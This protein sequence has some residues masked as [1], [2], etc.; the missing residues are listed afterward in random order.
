MTARRGRYP[1]MRERIL[2]LSFVDPVTECWL[3]LGK[4]TRGKTGNAPPRPRMNVWQDGKARTVGAHREAY[5]AFNGPILAGFEVGH[6][7]ENTLCVNPGHLRAVTHGENMETENAA[8]TR[9]REA[10]LAA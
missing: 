2:A 6:T 5:R 3:W 4:V 8:R 10:R 1:N 9:R 7:C